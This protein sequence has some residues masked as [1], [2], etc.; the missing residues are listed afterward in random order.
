MIARLALALALGC[1]GGS[2]SAP[3]PRPAPEAGQGE[4][5]G[6]DEASAAAVAAIERAVNQENAAIHDCWA[7]GAADDYQLEGEVVLSVVLGS[8]DTAEKVEVVRDSTGDGVLVDCLKALWAA[9]RWPAGVFAAGDAVQ[10]PPFRF[11]A[12]SGQNVVSSAHVPRHPLGAGGPAAASSAQVLLH[13]GNSGNS[14]GAL[15]LLEMAPGMKVPRHRHG[16]AELLLFISGRGKMG[17]R[18]VQ[19]G[20]GIYIPAGTPHEF[21]ND[22]AEPVVA[23]QLY[24]AAGP[25]RRFLG[26]SD[27]GTTPVEPGQKGQKGVTGGGAV[28]I[29]NAARARAHSIIDGK[30]KAQIVFD[31]ASARDDAASLIAL[32]LDPG[33]EVPG[34]VHDGSSEFLIFLEGSGVM[35]VDGE[36]TPVRAG[37]AIQVPSGVEHSFRAAADVP[38]KAVQFYAPAGP[39]Q[40]FKSKGTRP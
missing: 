10:L 34:H 5:E 24:A 17:G 36:E 11:G 19:A 21:E 37:D 39:E 29:A 26:Q 32:T 1:G 14:A 13:P 15:S 27:P 3:S 2:A 16:S 28:R 12:P 23:V 9:H 30:G 8:A 7:K 22:G 33:A 4:E 38:V 35:I 31:A 6:P 18:K 20:D 40:R 25:E